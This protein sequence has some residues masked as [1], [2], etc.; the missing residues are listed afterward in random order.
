[1]FKRAILVL[2]GSVLGTFVGS[3]TSLRTKTKWLE[4]GFSVL[5]ISLAVIVVIKIRK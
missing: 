1:M 2:V 4:L 3:K 5:I